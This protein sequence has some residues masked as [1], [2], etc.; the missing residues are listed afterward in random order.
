MHNRHK[1]KMIT[2]DSY[3]SQMTK[4]QGKI[5]QDMDRYCQEKDTKESM[6]IYKDKQEQKILITQQEERVKEQ[7]FKIE[8]DIRK[9][10]EAVARNLEKVKVVYFN[11]LDNYMDNFKQE[12][13]NIEYSVNVF[14][15]QKYK[16]NFSQYTNFIKNKMFRLD[17]DGQ[18]DYL[19][20]LRE[21][22]AKN[23]QDKK[24]L[25]ELKEKFCC[26]ENGIKTL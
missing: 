2:Y 17:R 26:G 13:E 10:Q 8:T 20:Q 4:N 16:F 25:R 24:L 1:D 11:S 12:I 14:D 7:K 3:I 15:T 5:V 9:I 22:N 19:K 18:T 6:K 21:M 23:V